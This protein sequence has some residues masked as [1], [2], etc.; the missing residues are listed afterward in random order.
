MDI[1][2]TKDNLVINDSLSLKDP[3]IGW[4]K[5]HPDRWSL[6]TH[7]NETTKTL[8]E[9]SLLPPKPGFCVICAVNHKSN[10]PH[11]PESIYYRFKFFQLYNRFPTWADAIAHLP[12][13]KQKFIKNFVINNSDDWKNCESPISQPYKKQE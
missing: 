11:N 13:D 2:N 6:K 5:N 4:E 7:I 12:K 3:E 1:K 10:R 9:W 8:K